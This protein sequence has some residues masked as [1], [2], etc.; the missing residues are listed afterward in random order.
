MQTCKHPELYKTSIKQS[1]A[2][3]QSLLDKQV[4]TQLMKG[5]HYLC[6]RVCLLGSISLVGIHVGCLQRNQHLIGKD[7]EVQLGR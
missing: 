5:F 3:E 7:F 1:A 4:N 2:T 6:V